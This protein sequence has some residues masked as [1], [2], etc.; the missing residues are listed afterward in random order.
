MI[1]QHCDLDD[2]YICLHDC[3]AEKMAFDDGVLSFIFPEGFWVFP[4]HPLNHSDNTVR[5]NSSQ[6]DF[7]ILDKEIDGISVYV[8]QKNR[9]GKVIRVDWEPENFINAV[10]AGDFRVEFLTRFKSYQFYLFKCWVWYDKSP[11]HLECE[12]L[13]HSENVSYCWNELRYDRRW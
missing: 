5:T 2:N 3:H 7:Q 4:E 13:L 12:I 6:A 11:Y 1:Y 10:N 8:F 9:R